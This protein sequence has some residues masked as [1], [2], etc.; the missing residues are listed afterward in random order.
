MGAGRVA[1]AGA[2]GATG[3]PGVGAA[4]DAGAGGAWNE[5]TGAEAVPGG[6]LAAGGGS[7]GAAEGG[8]SGRAAPAAAP[9]GSAGRPSRCTPNTAPQTEQRAR[10]PASGTLAGSTRNTVAQLGHVTFIG[11]SS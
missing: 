7:G 6:I 2:E 8:A 11:S 9:T 1:G 10:T 5:G 3:G 4:G